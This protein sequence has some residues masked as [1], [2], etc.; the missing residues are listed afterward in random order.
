MSI[1]NNTVVANLL[2]SCY[3]HKDPAWLDE[4]GKT[5][6]IIERIWDWFIHL[7]GFESNIHKKF[8]LLMQTISQATFEELPKYQY[9]KIHYTILEIFE[10]IYPYTAQQDKEYQ[11]TLLQTTLYKDYTNF[12]ETTHNLY[13]QLSFKEKLEKTIPSGIETRGR[14]K[15]CLYRE[16]N[17]CFAIAALQTFFASSF[18]TQLLQENYQLQRRNDEPL[19]IWIARQQLVDHLKILSEI[20]QDPIKYDIDNFPIT[21]LLNSLW[22]NTSLIAK[23]K[24]QIFSRKDL[25]LPKEQL[26]PGEFLQYLFELLDIKPQ[27]PTKPTNASSC[28]ILDRENYE[29]IKRDNKGQEIDSTIKLKIKAML[30]SPPILSLNKK[31]PSNTVTM[32]NIIDEEFTPKS[33]SNTLRQDALDEVKKDATVIFVKSTQKHLGIHEGFSPFNNLYI[34][35]NRRNSNHTRNN[36]AIQE[37]NQQIKICFHECKCRLTEKDPDQEKEPDQY[38]CDSNDF[39]KQY[40]AI[41]KPVAVICHNGYLSSSS[42]GGHYYTYKPVVNPKKPEEKNWALFNDTEFKWVDRDITNP[43]DPQSPAHIASHAY[44]ILYETTQ[45]TEQDSSQQ[46]VD[47]TSHEQQGEDKGE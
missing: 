38:I 22:E 39:G 1:T 11:P 35:L 7:L 24:Y 17:T 9:D 23:S 16:G 15:G 33:S 43:K 19:N 31:P 5:I 25:Q 10:K 2:D 28:W 27:D 41:L 21:Y 4:N 30:Y 13:E 45:V 8:S 32:Q 47:Q 3:Y 46:L 42:S 29:H 12:R 40:E 37:W 34:V 26:D 20:M 44:C 6:G 14:E 36:V 18:A